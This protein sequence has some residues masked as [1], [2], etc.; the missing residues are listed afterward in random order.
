MAKTVNFTGAVDPV[1]LQRAKVVAAKAQTSINAL[2]NAELRYLVETFEAGEASGK[3]N[4]RALLDFSLGRADEAT[5]L[6]ALGTDCRL[7]SKPEPPRRPNFEPGVEADYEG[8]GC[9]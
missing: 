9:G 3:Q 8:V 5:T 6:Q 2:F 4:F 1:L 7:R